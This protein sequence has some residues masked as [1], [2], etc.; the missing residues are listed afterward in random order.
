MGLEEITTAA[1]V[2]QATSPYGI[3]AF[4]GWAFWRTSEKKDQAVRELHEQI[5]KMAQ[6]QTEAVA[7]MEGA[8]DALT[9]VIERR[10][11]G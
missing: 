10:F 5:L 9:S 4:L 8:L 3:V 6:A 2:L 1:T 11:R 7:R